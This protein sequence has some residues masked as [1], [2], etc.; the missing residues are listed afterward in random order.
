MVTIKIKLKNVYL[1]LQGIWNN[2]SWD[3][4]TL[5]LSTINI[6]YELYGEYD[7]LYIK[8]DKD[9][10]TQEKAYNPKDVIHLASAIECNCKYLVTLDK[11]FIKKIENLPKGHMPIPKTLEPTE[12]QNILGIPNK[13]FK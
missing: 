1:I 4:V 7:E 2:P 3:T 11:P 10:K 12:L 6:C 8:P 5:S 9:E 13:I